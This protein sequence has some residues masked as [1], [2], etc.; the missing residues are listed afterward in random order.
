IYF[1]RQQITERLQQITSQL[2]D[3]IEP[4]LGPVAT[5]LG[6]VFMYTI[7]PEPDAEGAWSATDMRTLQDWVVRPQLR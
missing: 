5:G 7:E 2:P 4:M 1:A 3:G 6:E